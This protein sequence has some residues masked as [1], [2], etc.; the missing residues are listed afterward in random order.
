[1]FLLISTRGC[2]CFDIKTWGQLSRSYFFRTLGATLT[3][4]NTIAVLLT[5]YSK[6]SWNNPW[7]IARWF[8]RNVSSQQILTWGVW[9]IL[10]MKGKTIFYW[11]I[12]LWV[13]VLRFDMENLR[14]CGPKNSSRILLWLTPGFFSGIWWQQWRQSFM[15]YLKVIYINLGLT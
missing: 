3:I 13:L 7:K 1:M 6:K 5:S 2:L 9:L 8:C 10:Q 11:L 4:V 15:P 14:N 12:Q